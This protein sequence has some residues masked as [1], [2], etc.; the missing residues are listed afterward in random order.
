MREIIR[1]IFL[2]LSYLKEIFCLLLFYKHAKNKYKNRN[3]WLISERGTE[4]RD[5]GAWLFKYIRTNYPDQEVYY[6]ISADSSDLKNIEQY[7]NILYSNTHRHRLMFYGAKVLISAHVM[8]GFTTNLS[9]YLHLNRNKWFREWFKDNRKIVFLQHGITKDDYQPYYK[10]NTQLDLFICG[11]KTESDYIYSHYH[12]QN[13]EVKYTGF[14]RFDN[15][16]NHK[17]INQILV[18]PTWRRYLAGSS[19]HIF[20]ESDYFKTW[21]SLIHSNNL[22]A[23]LKKYKLKLV[24]YLHHG[25]QPYTGLFNVS[26]DNIIIADNNHYDVQT[27]LMQSKL[28]ISDYSSVCFDFAYMEKPVIYYQFDSDQ[29][30]AKHFK[31]GYF[32]YEKMGFGSVVEYEEEVI[33]NLKQICDAQFKPSAI[34]LKRMNDFFPIHDSENCSRIYR[35]IKQIAPSRELTDC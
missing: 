17:E 9:F 26:D 18:M 5:N 31:K 10:E 11:A 16:A 19:K 30:F 3:I 4:A 1:L 15:L 2:G 25:M 14:A 35:V 7:G 13:G 6:V 34:Y 27:L 24:F 33:S 12:Y 20:T 23:F 29:F 8:G 21:N 28:L 22:S 32:D